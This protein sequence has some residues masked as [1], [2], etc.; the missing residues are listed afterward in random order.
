MSGNP[1]EEFT[2]L[3]SV[4]TKILLV[5]L[6]LSIAALLITGFLAFTQIGEV[7]RFA[8]DSNSNLGNRASNDSAIALEDDARTSL[9]RLVK[10][11][12]DISNIIFERVGG[13]TN[14]MAYYAAEIMADPAMVRSRH[15]YSQ[16]E[17]PVDPRATSV[18]YLAPGV[19]ENIPI[20]ERDAAGM[21]DQIFIPIYTT[22]TDLEGVYVGTDSG[23]T[24][25]YPWTDGLN[26]TFDPRLRDWFIQAK[27]TGNITWSEPYVDL[28]GNG[29]MVTCSK[30]VYNLKEGWTWVIGADVTIETINQNI[31]GTQVGDRGYAM[32]LDEQG[33]VITRPGLSAGDMR[34]DETF[35]T[36]NLL[37][38][39]NSGLVATVTKMTAGETG[40]SRVTFD[41]GDR[42]IAYAPVTSVN[43]SV[44]LVMPV[45][46]VIAPA[47]ETKERILNAS[48]ETASHITRQ[49]EVM[50]T[51]FII[52]FIGLL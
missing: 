22:D 47:Y 8:L 50:R 32:L 1:N 45:E 46:E 39:N 35:V 42:F 43:W 19:E 41:D 20:K 40:I 30:P 7:S 25:V 27:K 31:I 18:L 36:E 13:E 3:F 44:A 37:M 38:S 23:M 52:T 24:L 5:F 17:K 29:L 33:N 28:L 12:A 9:L 26:A 15:F 49:Q 2:I 16:H 21:I 10:D 34:W 51:F 14:V 4:R 11:Q 6:A 48:S